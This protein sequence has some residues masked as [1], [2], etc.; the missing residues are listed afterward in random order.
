MIAR[1]LLAAAL[2]LLP[3]FAF[4][5]TYPGGFV[6]PPGSV[7]GPAGT[8]PGLVC[9]AGWFRVSDTSCSPVVFPAGNS[10]SISTFGAVDP[11]GVVD[12]TAAFQKATSEASQYGTVSIP[13]GTYKIS[14][15]INLAAYQ[16]LVGANGG[17]VVLKWAGDNSSD[18]ISNSVAQLGE[19]LI[20]VTIDAGSGTSLNLLHLQDVQQSYFSNV[21]MNG[22]NGSGNTCLYLQAGVFGTGN[23]H[24]TVLNYFPYIQGMGCQNGAEFNGNST[25]PTVASDNR[26]GTIDMEG[27]SGGAGTMFNFVQWTD[28]NNFFDARCSLAADSSTCFGLDTGTPATN[29][30][31]YDNNFFY[32]DC[33]AFGAVSVQTC[34]TMNNT[35]EFV[36]SALYHS[37]D[38][39]PGTLTNCPN[40][41]GNASC[42]NSTQYVTSYH[43]ML[44]NSP[45]GGAPQMNII[46]AGET[47]LFPGA[48][49]S[50]GPIRLQDANSFQAI[51]NQDAS[52]NFTIYNNGE[53]LKIDSGGNYTFDGSG[54]TTLSSG[55]V[56]GLLGGTASAGPINIANG[57]AYHAILNQDAS[58][59]F[60]IYDNGIRLTLDAA[61]NIDFNQHLFA[62]GTAITIASGGCTS[63]AVTE[64]SGTASFEI[65]I[66]SSCSGSQPLVLT[67]ATAPDGW[68]CHADDITHPAQIHQTAYG[69]TSVT[70]T[71]YPLA[72]GAAQAWTAADVVVGMCTA[73]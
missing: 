47:Y 31:V 22:E 63:P 8:G 25:G 37:P 50:T 40:S 54:G 32:A 42:P 38:T 56:L 20:N 43:I 69:T 3:V 13:T 39:F 30:G 59:L 24:N 21:F 45:G 35:K 61:G 48:T 33:D 16:C 12:S 58:S 14:S 19:C 55:G 5:Q 67:F 1:F 34:L 62:N 2:W 53:R 60:T 18:V 29:E 46:S 51:L 15:T 17:A 73:F 28:T 27:S 10:T 72:G 11:T 57:G 64:S 68:V 9:Q 66:G 23:A 71:N 49:E 41:G 4:G 65:T 44:A 6:Q 7:G 52:S 26:F 70:L 36:I